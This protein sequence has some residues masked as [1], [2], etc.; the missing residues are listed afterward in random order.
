MNL[1]IQS[2]RNLNILD[3]DYAKAV[4]TAGGIPVPIL[5]IGDSIPALV[6]QLDG[7]IFSG[8]ADI[9][10]HFYKEKQLHAARISPS[11]DQRTKFELKLFS[12][13]A[14][15][16]KPV[17][18]ICH[19]AQLVSVALGG[20]LY[21]DIPLQIPRSIKHGAGTR[22]EKVF[23]QVRIIEGTRLFSIMGAGSIR[24][25][26]SHHQSIKDTGK[27]L[28]LAAISPDGVI[29]AL[30]TRGRTFLLAVQWHP[31]KINHDRYTKK[32]FAAFIDAARK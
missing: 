12:T 24:V 27:S 7:F 16:K 19:G 20:S 14:K 11:P 22:G 5:S 6:R 10:P 3:Q 9:H 18:A 13:A 25:R 23:H 32:L 15:A 4:L 17:L 2:A 1:E 29:E 28:K 26:S 31:E 8:G 30:E 21:Q